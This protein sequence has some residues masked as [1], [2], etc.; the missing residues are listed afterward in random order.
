MATFADR[1]TERVAQVGAPI[2]VGLDP[3]LDLIPGMPSEDEPDIVA[4]AVYQFCEQAIEALA[5][6]AAVLKPQAAFF[7]QLGAP[8]VAVL[9]RVIA[10]A[11]SQGLFVLLDAKR[12]DI[13]STAR[14][15]ARATLS[16]AGPM[17]ADAVT[18]SPYLGPESL[19]PFEALFS[20][21]KGIFVLVRTSNPGA[22]P[23]QR[24]LG[25][26]DAVA[27]WVAK[28]PGSAGAVVGATLPAEECRAWR[29]KLPDT[30]LLL[31]GF[32]AQGAA[33]E[34][35]APFLANGGR[36]LAAAARSV[37]FGSDA[38]HEVRDRIA[39]RARAFA[40]SVAELHR[41]G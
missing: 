18:V 4:R 3:H 28:H 11:Q 39:E 16:D 37:L 10:L 31:P 8:G 25:V 20:E 24:D 29:A 36:G 12:G 40:A 2:C 35:A 41:N 1:L 17:R 6:V 26:A 38:P 15:Y 33:V 5:P 7:E 23:W 13:G 22:G 27:E 14:A 9:Q 32:G 19:Q 30:W 21:G 34:Q